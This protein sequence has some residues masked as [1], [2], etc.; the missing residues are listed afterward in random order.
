MVLK[1]NPKGKGIMEKA[2][3][4]PINIQPTIGVLLN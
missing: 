4:Y 1:K 3:D 2:H